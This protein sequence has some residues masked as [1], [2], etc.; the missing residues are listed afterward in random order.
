MNTVII[1]VDFSDVSLN[2]AAY[3]VKLLSVSPETE[4]ILYH[5]FDKPEAYDNR[6]E[7]LQKLKEELLQNRTA[8]INLL[9]EQGDFT[10]ELEKLARHRDADL[11]IMGITDRNPLV[12]IFKGNN[13]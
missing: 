8:N 11:I 1:P 13:A 7:S 2:A 5:V 10:D 12:Q 3:G 9:A 4:I 6:M